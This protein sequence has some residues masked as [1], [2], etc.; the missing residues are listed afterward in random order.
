RLDNL[1]NPSRDRPNLTYEFMGVTRVWRWTKNRMQAAADAGL[2][3]QGKPG[4][5]PQLKRYLDEQRGRPLGDVWTDIP[6]LNSQAQERLGYPTQKPVQLL[7]RI[8]RLAS[9]EGDV[10]LDPFAGCGTTID[11]AQNSGA[12]GSAWTSRTLPST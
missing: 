6:P 5:V 7:E 10:V 9:N 11:A 8:L 4:N 3:Y 2:I 1:I 12:I